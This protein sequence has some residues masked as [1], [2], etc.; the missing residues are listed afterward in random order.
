MCTLSC[1]KKSL[2]HHARALFHSLPHA[3][4]P[5]THFHNVCHSIPGNEACT[6]R[7]V[8]HERAWRSRIHS[9][10]RTPASSPFVSQP[11][12]PTIYISNE[13]WCLT[14]R[15]DASDGCV[16]GFV[17]LS[18]LRLRSQTR[19]AKCSVRYDAYKTGV[20]LQGPETQTP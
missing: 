3:S 15:Q 20:H 16:L 6:V 1:L 17:P 10:E 8:K 11:A 2:M 19:I 4:C 14:L 9:S 18:G 13:H 7:Q 5:K 12:G